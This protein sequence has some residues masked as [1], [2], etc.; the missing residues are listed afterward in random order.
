[1]NRILPVITAIAL[2]GMVF[3]ACGQNNNKKTNT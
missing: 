1:M 3:T 2:M